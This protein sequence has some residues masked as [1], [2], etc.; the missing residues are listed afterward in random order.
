MPTQESGTTWMTHPWPPGTLTFL[1]YSIDE[2]SPTQTPSGTPLILVSRTEVLALILRFKLHPLC[3]LCRLRFLC[4]PLYAVYGVA[5]SRTRLQQLS[6]SSSSSFIHGSCW[7]DRVSAL[8]TLSCYIP[9]SEPSG[10]ASW[11]PHVLKFYGRTQC[12]LVLACILF[13]LPA[14]GFTWWPEADPLTVICLSLLWGLGE[15][16]TVA[17]P[18]LLLTRSPAFTK[19][20]ISFERSDDENHLGI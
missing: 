1:D 6:S 7:S 16:F 19:A 14:G 11:L 15:R 17:W 4:P 20:Q 10:S 18:L 9:T 8:W 3:P 2:S 13:H 12:L 5:Q